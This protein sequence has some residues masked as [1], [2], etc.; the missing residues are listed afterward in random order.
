LQKENQPQVGCDEKPTTIKM[1]ISSGEEK[2][3]N[4]GDLF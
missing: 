2:K 4:Y 3:I 1:K